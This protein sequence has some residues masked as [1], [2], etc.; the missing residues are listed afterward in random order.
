MK[1]FVGE[2]LHSR[3][4]LF[5]ATPLATLLAIAAGLLMG[6]GAFTFYYGEG[7]SYLSKNPKACANCHVM[8]HQY[9]NWIASGH[10]HVATCNDCHL[11]ANLILKYLTKVRNGWNHS[12]A[13]TLEHFHEPIRIKGFNQDILQAN[14]ERCHESL[15][16]DAVAYP[17]HQYQN[18]IFRNLADNRATK[19]N[20]IHC[21]RNVGHFPMN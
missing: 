8:N 9:D 11:P 17:E 16:K 21:H 20:C 18:Q 4:N 5:W 2:F 13:F 19:M 14:C 3:L 6:L 1:F 10:H 7:F 12:L 15:I